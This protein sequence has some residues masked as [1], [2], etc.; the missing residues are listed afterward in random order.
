LR[1]TSRQLE[2]VVH[3]NSD[4]NELN[5]YVRSIPADKRL[6]YMHTTERLDVIANF[7]KAAE[8]AT[9]EYITFI[10]D[11][12]GVNPEIVEAA[13]WANRH[14]LDSLLPSR[15]AQYRWPDFRS[16]LY[17]SKMAGEISIKTFSGKISFPDAE[18]SMRKCARTAG[19]VFGSLPKIY[20]GLV[21]LNCLKQV[22]E[23]AGTFFPGP[24]PDLAGAVAVAGFVKRMSE[25]D[26]P[27]FLPGASGGSTAGWGASKKH[28]GLLEDY[29]HL[30]ERYIKG[31]SQ[32]VPKFFSGSTI[33]GEDAVQALTAIGRTDILRHFNVPLLHAQ[34]AVF[35]PK[36]LNV[37]MRN[38]LPALK[39]MQ[40]G[41]FAGII[42]FSIEYINI[43]G[44]RVKYLIENLT[45]INRAN[46]SHII[47]G[48]YGIDVATSILLEYLNQNKISLAHYLLEC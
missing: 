43:W 32:I 47:R 9:G 28:Q 21:R 38:F 30:P 2:I 39:Q 4:D 37:T 16:Y 17:G 18:D 24:S 19:S 36:Y 29:P 1:I 35:N 6:T 40:M 10:G 15:P 41:Y 3:D 23:I 48:V 7:E 27:L 46:S 33:W 13:I 44:T 34:C 20:Y 14:C 22:R 5:D 42:R 12:D 26:Y 45:H 25:I 31:W 8:R 11:D